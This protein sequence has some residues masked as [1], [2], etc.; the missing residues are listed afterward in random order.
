MPGRV[1][2]PEARRATRRGTDYWHNGPSRQP[3]PESDDCKAMSDDT[4]ITELLEQMG[5]DEALLK[6]VAGLYLADHAPAIARMRAAL[7]AGDRDG[8]HSVA[9]SLKGSA[10]GF[11]AKAAVA[12]AQEIE[13]ACRADRLDQARAPVEA[14]AQALEDL[15]AR[16][17]AALSEAP[18]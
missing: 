13:I 3:D 11:G 15:A 6:Q 10:A 12:H 14:F 9:H 18:R 7:A 16:L 1:I 17:R 2:L 4:H 8:L 5:G